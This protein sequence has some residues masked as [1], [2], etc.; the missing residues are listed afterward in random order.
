MENGNKHFYYRTSNARSGAAAAALDSLIMILEKDF[1]DI[2]I[3]LT[4][5][6][7]EDPCGILVAERINGEWLLIDV[8]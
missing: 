7:E 6:E 8:N 4:I 1:Q 3:D 2:S 5:W